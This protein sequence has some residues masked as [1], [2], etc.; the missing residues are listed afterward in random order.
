VDLVAQVIDYAIIT[1]DVDGLVRSWNAG[2]E[3]VKGYRAEEI[4]GHSF[5]SFYPPRTATRACRSVCWRELA[6]RGASSTRGGGCA[7]TAPASGVTWSSPRCVT[8]AAR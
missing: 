8:T 3:R 1:L 7:R 5:E 4:L 2:A 6:P